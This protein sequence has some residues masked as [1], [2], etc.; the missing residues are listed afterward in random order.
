ME[1][2]GS[3][4]GTGYCGLERPFCVSVAFISRS[5]AEDRNVSLRFCFREPRFHR[6]LCLCVLKMVVRG[7]F[8]FLR[9]LSLSKEDGGELAK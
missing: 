3:E 5:A 6:L 2:E 9:V 1:T 4:G 8:C 7:G